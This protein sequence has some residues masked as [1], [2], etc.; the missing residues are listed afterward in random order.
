M[1]TREGFW[2]AVTALGVFLWAQPAPAVT[3]Q[4]EIISAD[5]NPEVEVTNVRAEDGSVTGTVTNR[6]SQPVRNVRVLIDHVWHWKNERHP[7]EDNPGRAEFYTIQGEIPPGGSLP[8]KLDE[9]PLPRRS[10]GRFQTI[11]H[12]IEYVQIGTVAADQPRSYGRPGTYPPSAPSTGAYPS[13]PSRYPSGTYE[14]S[15]D[16]PQDYPPVGA[17]GGG[18]QL[19]IERGK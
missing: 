12:V 11:A 2:L 19:P 4:T 18:T 6:S 1:R 10:D 8:F 7:G 16:N 14:P 15:T 17:P 3:Q 5:T 13:A 9:A